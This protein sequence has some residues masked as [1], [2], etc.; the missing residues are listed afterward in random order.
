[1]SNRSCDNCGHE[2]APDAPTCERCGIPFRLTTGDVVAIAAAGLLL[3]GLVWWL[4][5]L[6]AR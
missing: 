4:V 5:W 2:N 1:M 3:C 6:A